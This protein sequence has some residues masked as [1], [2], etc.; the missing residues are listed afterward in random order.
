MA[1]YADFRAALR[2]E[3]GAAWP[4]VVGHT[5]YDAIELLAIPFERKAG[6][7]TPE[8]PL[9]VLDI[10]RRADPTWGADA[11]HEAW[12]VAIYRVMK[13]DDDLTAAEEALTVL[14]RRLYNN[15][16]P[17]GFLTAWPGTSFSMRLPL[18]QYFLSTGK[19]FWAGA[20][21]PRYVLG[22]TS[23]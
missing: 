15:P 9:C 13:N 19:P 14:Q 5:I 20:V 7:G 10:D 17:L 4:E 2:A 12:D 6:G 11:T 1:Y 22:E 16:L 8:L 3:I 18:N 23:G 21:L